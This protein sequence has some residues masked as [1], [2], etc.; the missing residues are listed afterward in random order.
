[1][2]QKSWVART[3]QEPV[4]LGLFFSVWSPHNRKKAF[5]FNKRIISRLALEMLLVT[6]LVFCTQHN[7]CKLDSLNNGNSCKLNNCTVS[8]L[9]WTFCLVLRVF[10]L[11]AFYHIVMSLLRKSVE[12]IIGL[13]ERNLLSRTVE[14][15]HSKHSK[16]DIGRSVGRPTNRLTNQPTIWWQIFLFQ[17]MFAEAYIII[18]HIYRHTYLCMHI[19]MLTQPDMHTQMHACTPARTHTHTHHLYNRNDPHCTFNSIK[20]N[21]LSKTNIFMCVGFLENI[22]Y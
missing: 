15:V 4:V 19:Q 2:S 8:S 18:N 5:F 14:V 13:K 16:T 10:S 20:I 17:T 22:I 7:P 3:K 11:Q 9:H 1:M 21:I 12:E 6:A